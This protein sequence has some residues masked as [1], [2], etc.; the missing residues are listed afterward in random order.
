MGIDLKRVIFSTSLFISA[1]ISLPAQAVV[2]GDALPAIAVKG[3]SAP[4]LNQTAMQGKVT[5]I[6]FWATWCAACKVEIK[7]MEEQFKAF[8]GEKDFQM[9]YVSL[10][11]DP[12]KAAEWFATNLRDP[13][14]MLKHLYLDQAFE[15]AET[16][17]VESF[18]MTFIVDRT[19]KVSY[20]QAG[21]KEGENSTE[22]MVKAIAQML[23]Q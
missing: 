6:N 19:G 13:Q 1:A 5:M 17:K 16:L 8:A 4:E 21:F 11:K 9:A 22:E 10:D 15:A 20:V 2:K 23:R 7:E 3:H 12:A 14:Q 18:P